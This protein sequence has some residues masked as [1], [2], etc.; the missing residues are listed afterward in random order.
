MKVFILLVVIIS[1][2]TLAN[3]PKLDAVLD[4]PAI[5]ISSELNKTTQI[6]SKGQPLQFAVPTE[7]TPVL[8]SNN[9]NQ[10]GQWDQ[11]EDG[12]WVWRI[13]VHSD[14][15]LSLDFGLKNYY[16][17]PTAQLSFYDWSGDLVKGPF[18]D[19]KNKDHKQLW[20][21]TIIGDTVTLELRVADKYKNYVSFTVNNISRGFRSI[22]QDI[23]LIPKMG[24]QKFWK[25]QDQYA[26]KSGS[27]NV[28]VVC[29]DADEWRDQIRSVAR[30]IRSGSFL[31]TGQM[32]NN[33]ANDGKPL[34]LTANHCGFDSS[35]A[36]SINLWW[37]Y[38]S[39]QC[40]APGS[41][42]SSSP[43]SIA[44]FND[45]QSGS[46]FRA[47][48]PLGD[49]ALLELDDLPNSD[50][51]VFYTGWD[52]SDTAPSSATAIHH[53]SG[54][55]KRISFEN[56]PSSITG[57]S[58][59]A[60]GA[61]S[62]IRIA[63]WDLGT[64]E[65]GSSGSGLWNS[66]KLLVGQLHGGGAACGNDQPDW[67]G[68]I[69]VA[70]DGGGTESSR[71]KDWLD[72]NNTGIQSLQGLGECEAITV[73][74]IQASSSETIGV[75]QNFSV[76]VSGG[77]APY[78]YA[79]DVN[80]DSATDGTE[81]SI[82]ATY[83][84][85][86]VGNVNVTIT[87]SEG[88]TNGNSKAVVIESPQI[89]LFNSAPTIPAAQEICGNNNGFIDPGE[90][91]RIPVSL[92]NN[93]FA[94]AQNAYAVFNKNSGTTEFIATASDDF[95]NT[96]GTCG[97]EFIDISTTGTE[98]TIIDASPEDELPA[99]DEGIAA[100]NLSEPFDLYGR[101]INSLYLSTNGYISTNSAESGFDFDNDCPIPTFPNN[102][103]F[104][105][106]P[107]ARI[108]PF[109]DDLITQNI[110]H[111]HFST[112]PR[113]SGSSLAQSCD[114]FMY[115][116]VGFFGQDNSAGELFNFEAILY[117]AINLW[118]YQYDGTEINSSSSTIGIQ[119][120][121]ATDGMAFACNTADSINSQEAICVYHKNSL[122]A[123]TNDTSK[124]HL[125]TPV[126]ALGNL[127]VSEQYSGVIDF[128]IDENATCGLPIGINL[129]AAVYNS[130]FDQSSSTVISTVL[131]D[132]GVCSAVSNCAPNGSNDIQPT[133]GLWY[134][135]RRSG[136]GND[137]HFTE[138][139]LVY[140]QYTALADRSPIWYITGSGVMQNNQVEND[141][142]KVF[143]NGPFLTST[144]STKSVGSSITTLIDANNAVQTRTINGEFSADLM[145]SFIFSND[146]TPQ[147]RTGLWYN[148]GQSG[149]GQ[150]IGTQGDVEVVVNYLY[151]NAGQ[152]YWVLGAG[153]NSAVNNIDMQY[154]DTFCPH[155]PVVPI[156]TIAE[157]VGRVRINYDGSNQSGT[158]EEMQINVS[159]SKHESQWNRA[160]LPLTL[161]T[162]PIEK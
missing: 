47:S 106:T 133:N 30:Y 12:S 123:P 116:D 82:S 117:P 60:S 2:Q 5:N 9:T 57:Y 144:Q 83:A 87:D 20:P 125:E 67:Y 150:T 14:N 4:L 132:K 15:A 97:R 66:N 27:C 74:L 100:V 145:N 8:V 68:R 19:Q 89:T 29:D 24:Q 126:L 148:A 10:G 22:W 43:I 157:P 53:P 161:L 129:Q 91:W 48:Y 80:A 63:D 18:T 141:I 139:G 11:L 1:S 72:P 112:C 52:R 152:P 107:S 65:G 151:D 39:N 128:S 55:A 49:M 85:K 149:W 40:R 99:Q 142:L 113:S 114:I 90:R 81:S 64:T 88:C 41:T 32:I 127:G 33:A 7:F 58:T 79:W 101:T 156:K 94:A 130:G 159:N 105:S 46:T 3:L 61:R 118:V 160:N 76:D 84:K 36:A 51:Q 17:P 92:Q 124:F 138:N 42:S 62:H 23:D 25:D 108:L 103:G 69:S 162:A 37:N 13:L 96:V 50:H 143:Y 31:C 21:G 26:I 110:Y 158:I 75:V 28:D 121:N 155:C 73:N 70:W 44:S 86:Y 136:N 102:S 71:L 147:Q 34:F 137:M 154:S 115:S 38:E 95:G 54:H 93:G 109:H 35:N 6:S 120:D 104:G 122:Q 56:D 78:S 98:L 131:G 77:V 146:P 119:N 45:T 135:P 16:M 111:Q 153:T 59:S 140:I 134:N